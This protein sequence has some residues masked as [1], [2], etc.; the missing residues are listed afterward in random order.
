MSEE[1]GSEHDLPRT[2]GLPPA[3]IL[4]VDDQPKN[5]LALSAML[6]P[7]GQEVIQA[8]SGREALRHLLR[9]EFALVLLDVQMPVLD[10]YEVAELIR[11][12]EK[13]RA[14]PIIFLTAIHRDQRLVARA[15]TVGAVDY[16][17]KPIDPEIL[18]S[19]VAVFIELYQKGQIISRQAE[20]LRRAT[21]R[22]FADF[23][24]VSEYRYTMLAESMPQIVWTTDRE[25]LLRYGNGRWFE[26]AGL[27]E[28]E[29]LSWRSIVHPSEYGEFTRVFAE[30]LSAGRAWEA[31]FRLGNVA[32]RRFRWHLVRMLPERDASGGIGAWVGTCTDIDARKRAEQAL[33]MLASLTRRLGELTDRSHGLDQVLAATLPV[34][35]DSAVLYLRSGEAVSKRASASVSS[36]VNLDD[37]R[38]DL[39]PSTVCFDGQPEILANV[40]EILEESGPA[41]AGEHIWFLHE[42]GISSYICWPLVI[43][44]RVFGSLVFLNRDPERHYLQSDVELAK[45][46]AGRMATALDNVGLYEL[47]QNERAKLQEANRAKDMFL[48]TVSHELRTPLNAIVGWGQMLRGGGLSHETEQ[49]AVDTIERNGRALAQ[50]VADLLD[51]S[52]VVSGNLHV[53]EGQVDLRAIVEA[54]L[55]AARPVAASSGVALEAQLP[56]QPL[57]TIGDATRLQQVVG[58]I[59]GNALKFTGRGGHVTLSLEV[60]GQS[61]R[62]AIQDDGPGIAPEF[63]P[64]MFD[65]FRQADSGTHRA[66]R[67][68]GLGLAIVKHLVELHGGHVTAHSEGLGKGALFVVTLPLLQPSETAA[69]EEAEILAAAAPEPEP[70]TTAERG[71]LAG[72]Y[73]LL[74]ED[75]PDGCDLMQMMLRRFGAEVTAVST[76]AAALES[77]RERRPDVLVSDIGLPDGDG[78]QLLKLVR[79]SNQDLPAVAVTAYASRQDVAKALAAG[80][81]AHVAKPVEPAQLS[82][83]VAHA[84][85]R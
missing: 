26:C 69:L 67:G 18:R 45:D 5:L 83:A 40:S 56:D 53:D 7:L 49:R 85:G 12:R 29:E 64:V 82:A 8:S 21:E 37:P 10:G 46:V 78:F 35:G 62:L 65:R 19:K 41:R 48:A 57:N 14:V 28:S 1:L 6:E 11:G 42:L 79:E 54:A 13:S 84:S 4:L 72:I 17:L 43:R 3:K 39:G 80:F 30:A 71:K 23:R 22:E 15:Y 34:L 44:E 63:L 70:A 50:L 38:F 61:A 31:E 73:A 36:V 51:V 74:V 75:D 9:D 2:A 20:E 25:G 33:Q 27:A 16:I 66:Q 32:E 52:R 47:A 76:A 55:D 77:V 60:D 68:L 59:L 58:N 24:R 81:Q